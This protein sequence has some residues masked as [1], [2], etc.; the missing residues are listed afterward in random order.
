MTGRRGRRGHAGE[1]GRNGTD[2]QPGWRGKSGPR[3]P[4]G[5]KG[6]PGEPGNPGAPGER[7]LPGKNGV[8]KNCQCGR[9]TPT[10]VFFLNSG[11]WISERYMLGFNNVRRARGSFH[12]KV[13]GPVTYVLHIGGRRSIIS[14]YI[15]YPRV[16]DSIRRCVIIIIH[17]IIVSSLLARLL[18]PL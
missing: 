5:A 6:P 17:F 4:R 16:C 9:N 7:G 1:P 8:I 10:Q 11:Y 3:G 14:V 13:L 15:M 12:L 18:S 2:G